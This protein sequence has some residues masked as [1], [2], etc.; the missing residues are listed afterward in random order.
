MQ[1]E[2][3]HIRIAEVK[4]AL[5]VCLPCLSGEAG[6]SQDP[7]AKVLS[8]VVGGLGDWCPAP[9]QVLTMRAKDIAPAY[10]GKLEVRV[11]R[12]APKIT[13]SRDLVELGV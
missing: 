1:I 8:G 13:M 6:V 12:R 11:T 4:H 5:V 9:V 3:R 2:M 10:G 7:L